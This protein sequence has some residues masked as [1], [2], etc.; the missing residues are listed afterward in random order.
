M[1]VSFA[2]EGQSSHQSVRRRWMSTAVY[3]GIA[4][5][6]AS[7]VSTAVVM[8][9]RSDKWWWDNHGGPDSSNFSNLD[10][11][12]KSNVSKL[13]V[14]WFYPYCTTVFNPIVVEDV[15]YTYGRNNSLIALDA[16]TGKEIWIHEG[17]AGINAPTVC[18]SP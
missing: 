12:N 9:A 3:L 14:A 17:L 8:A 2:R 6:L 11:I 16:T 7:T 13:E 4:L 15:M 5:A 1:D 18:E 10:Q